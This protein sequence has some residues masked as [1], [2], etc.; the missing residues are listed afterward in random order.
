MAT[1]IQDFR[2]AI[3]IDNK[4]AKTKFEETRQQIEAL[5]DELQG[6]K[7]EGKQNTKEYRDLNK[8]LQELKT[9]FADQRVE[10]GRSALT[11]SELKKTASSLKRELNNTV[12]GTK[13]WQELRSDLILTQ[14][15]MR[16]LEGQARETRISIGSIVDGFNKYAALGATAIA[17]LTG[18]TL[19]ARKCVDEFAQMQEAMAQV[20]K[21]TGMSVEAVDDL[22]EA[23]KQM[24]TRTP[25]ERLNA[26]AGDAGRLGITSRDA[27]LEFVDA[28]DKINVALGEDLGEDAV[29][30]IG[31]LA[32]MFGEDER[33]GLRGAMLATG[34][35]VNEL[36][37]S[38]SASESYLVDFT[39]RMAGVG[40]QAKI[41]QADIM[42]YASALDQ[43]MQQ[44]E[45]SATVFSQLITKMFQQPERFASLA[46]M[47]LKE[48]SGLLK[49]DAN[50]ALLKFLE[51]M[52]QKGGFDALAPMFEEMK[53][54]GTRAVGVLS[55]V[56]T[57][58]DQVRDAQA[59][60]NQAYTEGT[61]I[62]NEFN[63]QNN[64]VQAGI[65]K[66]K[67]NFQDV[68]V[69]LGEKLQPLMK[70]MIS[71]GS[72][73]VKGLAELVSFLTK[74][75]WV[76]LST[77]AAITAYTGVTKAATIAQ[78]LHT[79][80]TKAGSI[81]MAAF[82]AV[83]KA[84]PIG[85]IA[86]ALAAVVPLLLTFIGRTKEAANAQ[87]QLNA[88]FQKSDDLLSKWGKGMDGALV[89]ETEGEAKKLE[90]WI[91]AER[92][93]IA[94]MRADRMKAIDDDWLSSD[95]S[96][97]KMRKNFE[98]YF[99]ERT[100]V[101]MQGE[102]RLQELRANLTKYYSANSDWSAPGSSIDTWVN[103]PTS[104]VTGKE[105]DAAK[106]AAEARVK[107]EI[108]AEKNA[109]KQRLMAGSINEEQYQRA[110][111]DIEVRELT[112]RKALLEQ[113][114]EDT[115]DIQGDIYDKML[116]EANRLSAK[117]KEEM[118][119]R[120]AE[121]IKTLEREEQIAINEVKLESRNGDIVSE[122]EYQDKLLEITKRYLQR[123]RELYQALGKDTTDIDQKLLDMGVE[124][125]SSSLK[126]K[127]AADTA[128]GKQAIAGT[129]S[130]AEK[131]DILQAMYDADLI[132][133]EEYERTKTELA[134][135]QSKQRE[136]IAEASLQTVAQAAQAASELFTALQE[137]EIA[138]VESRYDKQ[139]KA[140]KKAGKDTTKLEEERE[141]TV[142][143]IRKKYADKQFAAQV[144][145]VISSTSVAAME[146]YKAMA[147]IPV[148]GPGL[149][150]AAAAAAIAAGAA[151]I[152][153]AKQ[154]RDEAKG[155]YKGGF[156]EDYERG[157]YTS[158]GDSRDT[159]GVIPVHKN[160]FVANHEAVQNPH[161]KQF[162]DV[163][164]MAQK[165]GSIRFI[166][167][168]GILEKLRL[169][170]GRY[171]GG[172]TARANTDT[173]DTA[174]NYSREMSRVIELLQVIAEKELIVDPRRMRDSIRQ[175]EVLERNVSR[176]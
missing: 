108:E 86:S 23:F 32:Q 94:E 145:Q 10:A 170:Q 156:S 34:S 159:A 21:Y 82:N 84:N 76:L 149:G 143:E 83:T 15:R 139:I 46:G 24:D 120:Q 58:L 1:K 135:E 157:G 162:L 144:L 49:T 114:G 27:V 111:Y 112:K 153:S 17:S 126:A 57:H 109:L 103:A 63:V 88:E 98:D 93:A 65:E 106:K 44:V 118:A 104:G 73:T 90:E 5:T 85:L 9:T 123:R 110:I 131:N 16:E 105:A 148:V 2:A 142:S 175:V 60:A 168:V 174:Y 28:A 113:F 150:A 47:K 115:T 155:L 147:G 154:A 160:E 70:Y 96:K 158:K 8:Q 72:L 30:N 101:V 37:Q 128:A 13:K 100:K 11:Y 4:E 61:S 138:K 36:A 117:D 51:T 66:A 80:A 54:N 31:K 3:R 116:A 67:K 71:T 152:I 92:K 132:T 146:A 43:N 89:E 77:T 75:Y 169:G 62:L 151:Q 121:Q 95:E 171:E 176:S 59:L 35:A 172:Y 33:M 69:E 22:N 42:G 167:T 81:A 163:F 14:N 137:R 133:Y 79:A 52:Q 20:R 68:R 18:L 12:P 55:S 64:T 50:A 91:A 130:Y 48:F 136:Q 164:D 125:R 129:S 97:A 41:S 45:T 173:S 78:S 19:T 40:Q 140:A 134:Q 102:K 7:E 99:A 56:A 119:K 53:L 166:D 38:S 127:R 26:L 161:V 74:Y 165:D 87:S 29:K 39:A 141:A 25:R 124:E 107:A 6:L 122:T